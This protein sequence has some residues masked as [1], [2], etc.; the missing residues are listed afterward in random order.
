MFCYSI[1]YLIKN[2][3]RKVDE[4][5]VHLQ[6]ILKTYFDNKSRKIL[7]FLQVTIKCV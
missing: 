5:S 3:I 6:L 2:L 7:K 4:F 1:K